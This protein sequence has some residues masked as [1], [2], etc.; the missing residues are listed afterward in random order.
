VG[1][2]SSRLS[3]ISEQVDCWSGPASGDGV[4]LVIHRHCIWSLQKQA[5]ACVLG[6]ALCSRPHW[7]STPSGIASHFHYYCLD[8]D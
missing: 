4:C 6:L 2:P 3:S 8:Q 1:P 7:R 5:T